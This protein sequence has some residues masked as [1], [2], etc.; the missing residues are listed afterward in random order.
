MQIVMREC[1]HGIMT[2]LANDLYIGGALAKYGEYSELEVQFLCKIVLPGH[3]V[4]D[5][6]ANIGCI[7]IPLARKV[8]P[9]GRVF[10]YEPQRIIH[11]MLCTN[12]I[13][14]GLQN[15]IAKNEALEWEVDE[16]G[17]PTVNYDALGNFGDVRMS[18]EESLE[19]VRCSTIDDLRLSHCRLIKIDVQGMED[20]VLTGAKS[21]IETCRP[22]LYVENDDL[23]NPDRLPT[24][25]RE[26]RY[27]TYWHRP[28][29]FN[30]DNYAKETENIFT[31]IVSLNVLG[32]PHEYRDKVKVD[33]ER[34]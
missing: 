19:T 15:V 24:T 10:A 1:R 8:G 14:S 11:Q 4:V 22:F 13:L 32:V 34:A 6:G 29:A 26:L 21:T 25:I 7:T 17:V 3:I 33:L 28:L 12:I 30:Q 2:F 31:N 18:R 5:A 27:D 16:I 9:S 20:R 23:D